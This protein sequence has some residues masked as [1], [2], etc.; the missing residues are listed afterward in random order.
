MPASSPT[1]RRANADEAELFIV[2]GDSR[3]RQRQEGA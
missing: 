2:E 3:R 1:A